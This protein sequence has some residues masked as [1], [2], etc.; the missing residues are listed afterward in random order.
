MK[1]LCSIFLFCLFF[2]MG[3]IAMALSAAAYIDPSSLTF[4]ISAVITAVVV[5]SASIGFYFNK[6]K[7]KLRRNTEDEVVAPVAQDE[8]IEDDGEFDDFEEEAEE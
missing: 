4:V 3:M 2:V 1:K 8:V 7:R 5:G 6:L